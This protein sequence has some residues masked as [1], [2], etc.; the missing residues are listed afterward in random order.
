VKGSLH[1]AG[2]GASPGAAV[3][4]AFLIDRRLA[5][6]PRRHLVEREIEAEVARLQ[7]AVTRSDEQLAEITRRLSGQPHEHGLIIEAHRLMLMDPALLEATEELI[8][9]DQINAEWAIRRVVKQLRSAFDSIDDPYFRDRRSDV[10]FVGDRIVRNLLGEKP[11]ISEPPPEDAVVVAFDLSP[12][13]TLMLLN[14]R[15]IAGIVTEEGGRTSHTAIVARAMEVPAV[16]GVER[17]SELV[18]RGDLIALDGSSG[19]VV[20]HPNLAEQ[21]GFLAAQSRWREQEVEAL[22]TRELE[23]ETSDGHR[24]TLRANI[25]LVE[26]VP[27]VVAHGADGVGLYRTEF[28]FLNRR[29]LPTEEEHYDTYRR[30][31]EALPGRRVTV[32][33]FDLGGDKALPGRARTEA[34]PSL[35][36]R[37]VRYC[38]AHP[39]LFFPQLRALWRASVHGELRVM[40]PMVSGLGE[41]RQAK[42]AFFEARRQVLAAG[43]PVAD[44]LPLGIMV[45]TPAAAMV[46]DQLARESAFFAIGTNDLIQYTLAIDRGNP[47]VAYLYRPLHPAL[48]RL[49]ERILGAARACDIPVSI[50][51]EMA[52]DPLCTL[53]L[54][55]LGCDELS[56][57]GTA[58]PPVKRILRLSSRA[59]ALALYEKARE[60]AAPEELEAFVRAEMSSRFPDLFVPAARADPVP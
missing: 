39:E 60:L 7:D 38:L 22:A 9:E 13:D 10:D 52:G 14:Q 16:L 26:E 18:G 21:Q 5:Q 54:L 34:N 57:P 25:E 45:E 20:V 12:A 6:E 29:D 55:A 40:L 24:V 19:A 23:A 49:I 15:K 2:V 27:S 47:D 8:R 30:L 53:V 35:G 1:L 3:G 37:A 31:L 50:C 28:L 51:G 32:R 46:A 58:I 36:L 11:D 43:H 4:H 48:L 42:A 56:M 17:V 33:T 41:L 44:E 59:D